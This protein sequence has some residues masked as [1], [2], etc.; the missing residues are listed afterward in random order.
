MW[1]RLEGPSCL[2]RHTA[3]VVLRPLSLG[4]SSH[5]GETV[6]HQTTRVLSSSVLQIHCSE[7]QACTEDVSILQG[8]VAVALSA[9]SARRKIS[10]SFDSWRF[11]LSTLSVKA[12][13]FRR[14]VVQ[15]VS[16]L[17]LGKRS[18]W[19]LAVTWCLFWTLA[20]C[21]DGCWPNVAMLLLCAKHF[22]HRVLTMCPGICGITLDVQQGRRAWPMILQAAWST[23]RW[24][25]SDVPSVLSGLACKA[26]SSCWCHWPTVPASTSPRGLFDVFAPLG[27]EDFLSFLVESDDFFAFVVTQYVDAGGR[28]TS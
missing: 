24:Y 14:V 12:L 2:P 6:L 15:W 28:G 21:S 4:A 13:G 11:A 8:E 20:S 7:Q 17:T 26:T 18:N 16:P 9:E 27:D 23:L 1:Y 19:A 5:V 25:S 3:V 22:K 10:S